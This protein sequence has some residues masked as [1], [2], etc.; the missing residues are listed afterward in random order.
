MT[1]HQ[2]TAYPPSQHVLSKKPHIA[3]FDQYLK[4]H[5]LSISQP[6]KYWAQEAEKFHWE[7]KW[8]KVYEGNIDVTKG[9]VNVK[10]FVNGKTN[11]AYNAI[12]RHVHAGLGSKVALHWVGNER[13]EAMDLTYK[14]MS[15]L[16]SQMANV[17]KFQGVKKG[18]VVTI[19]LPM[20]PLLPIA[21][22]ACGKIGA[23]HSIVFAGFSAHNLAMRMVDAKS[24]IILTADG[25][26][27][28]NKMIPLKDTVDEAIQLCANDGWEVRRNLVTHRLKNPIN[29]N[30]RVDM[31]LDQLIEG[32]SIE[33]DVEWCDAEDPLF[34]I[35][36]SGS[37]GKPKGIVHT[38]AGYM[39]YSARTFYYTFDYHPDEVYFCSCDAGWIS[40]ISY[41]IY[42]PTLNA[43]TQ[44]MFEGVPTYPD[45]GRFW[46]IIEKYKVN[47]FYTAPTAIRALKACPEEYVTKYDL[48]S[49]RV[50]GTVGEPIN[51]A[52]WKWY[53]EMIG[54]SRCAI[55]DCYWMSESSG[56]LICPLP[57]ATTLVPGSATF[58]M[59]GIDMVLLNDDKS[60]IEGE[61]KGFVAIRQSW[62]GMTRTIW[63]NQARY[64]AAYFEKFPGHFMTGDIGRRDS[65]GRYFI[66][67]RCDDVINVSA[68]R[69]STAE[70]EG[71]INSHPAVAEN[72]VVP[73]PHEIKGNTIYAYVVLR[74]DVEPTN[75]LKQEIL[76]AVS[77]EI[78]KIAKPET[79][80]WS[81]GLPKTRSG[82]IMRRILRKIA[83]GESDFG[84][85]STLTDPEVVNKLIKSKAE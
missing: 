60:E 63:G 69:L 85:T 7:K 74:D 34:M 52:A 64:E 65:E 14:D 81:P 47:S 1:S 25:V 51:E 57:G 73:V 72:A 15:E 4:Q 10:W 53:Y 62:P 5:Q 31:N 2:N 76:D 41:L 82:K 23:V 36:T 56:H 9:E 58:P 22:L 44:I 13:T 55:V 67:G 50:L 12:D 8:D 68:H 6:H 48:S 61:G 66:E 35:Y 78:G 54:K 17:L 38:Q 18:D 42:G 46:E 59:F 84:D 27:R 21:A 11:V 75:D 37:T 24:K 19:Y 79:I 16:V 26:M 43:A 70:V 83:V 49:L 77:K 71:A 20:I 3:S 80:H 40:G 30:H 28:G 45:A 29:W 32:A 33:C 39:I